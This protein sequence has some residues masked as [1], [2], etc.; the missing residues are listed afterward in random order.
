MVFKHKGSEF[1]NDKQKEVYKEKPP[2]IKN[3][4]FLLFA[5]CTICDKRFRM[6]VLK[7]D[8]SNTVF[9]PNC[10]L[11]GIRNYEFRLLKKEYPKDKF[12]EL[13][14]KDDISVIQDDQTKKV[15]N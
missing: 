9:C 14:R 5:Q 1:T 11:K 12:F 4:Y 7:S 15:I 10:N 13:L 8:F 3:R 6:K 2:E